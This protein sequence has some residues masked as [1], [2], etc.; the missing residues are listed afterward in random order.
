MALDKAI[1]ENKGELKAIIFEFEKE[2]NCLKDFLK[3]EQ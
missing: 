3:G 1:K 2:L